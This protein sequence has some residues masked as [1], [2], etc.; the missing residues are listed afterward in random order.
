V[1]PVA[2]EQA[3]NTLRHVDVWSSGSQTPTSVRGD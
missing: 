2:A 3:P 1:P